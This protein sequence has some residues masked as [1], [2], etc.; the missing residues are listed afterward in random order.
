M[1]VPGLGMCEYV[2]DRET[3]RE[4]ARE[5]E[6]ERERESER[7]R[8]RERESERARA[9]ERESKRA[10]E[11]PLKTEGRAK[12]IKAER[13]A[14]NIAVGSADDPCVCTHIHTHTQGL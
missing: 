3:E 10:R 5:R 13:E 4:R 1:R 8:E 11:L 2:C 6:R 14:S 12:V 9:R 7:A